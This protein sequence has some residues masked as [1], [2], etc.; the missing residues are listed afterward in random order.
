MLLCFVFTLFQLSHALLY[1]TLFS[2]TS[3]NFQSKDSKVLRNLTKMRYI[4]GVGDRTLTQC[5]DYCEQHSWCI[6]VED[7]MYVTD[8]LMLDMDNDLEYDHLTI[9]D[10]INVDGEQFVVLEEGLVGNI[11]VNNNFEIIEPLKIKNELNTS[12]IKTS[13]VHPE[14]QVPETEHTYFYGSN[15]PDSKGT[16]TFFMEH[17]VSND[18]FLFLDEFS[19][20]SQNFH[21]QPVNGIDDFTITTDAKIVGDKVFS[22]GVIETSTCRSPDTQEI[23]SPDAYVSNK[24]FKLFT[25]TIDKAYIECPLIQTET[26]QHCTYVTESNTLFS[27][28]DYVLNGN[29]HGFFKSLAIYDTNFQ[30]FGLLG[31]EHCHDVQFGSGTR[32]KATNTFKTGGDNVCKY[33]QFGFIKS[34][35]IPQGKNFPSLCKSGFGFDGRDDNK[36]CI[37][38]IE[39]TDDVLFEGL[40]SG[41]VPFGVIDDLQ[42]ASVFVEPYP[43]IDYDRVKEIVFNDTKYVY[44]DNS[45]CN[46]RESRDQLFVF[47]E[48]GISHP[49]LAP[50]AVSHNTAYSKV[51][52]YEKDQHHIWFKAGYLASNG[53]HL[54]KLPKNDLDDSKY[55]WLSINQRFDL[56]TGTIKNLVVQDNKLVLSLGT[57]QQPSIN[58]V[59]IPTE[60]ELIRWVHFNESDEK[61]ECNND[62]Y[63]IQTMKNHS[64]MSIACYKF[65]NRCSL[66]T[67]SI[68]SSRS[69]LNVDPNKDYVMTG[70]YRNTTSILCKEL[71]TESIPKPEI[72]SPFVGKISNHNV[73][74]DGGPNQSLKNPF[75]ETYYDRGRPLMGLL[76]DESTIQHFHYFNSPCENVNQG[77]I[78]I[79]GKDTFDCNDIRNG[80]ITHVTCSDSNCKNGVESLCVCSNKCSIN[81]PLKQSFIGHCPY[82]TVVVAI[83]CSEDDGNACNELVLTCAHVSPS[84]DE[85]HN[86]EFQQHSHEVDDVKLVAYIVEISLGILLS[87]VLCALPCIFCFKSDDNEN[88][89]LIETSSTTFKFD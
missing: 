26:D 25:T 45:E 35:D 52:I 86:C 5:S 83:E 48:N 49:T 54:R 63:I 17:W 85:K 81:E 39:G 88:E 69:C 62:E 64:T 79:T 34:F 31:A 70:I 10:I 6:A 76:L 75:I 15:G 50:G 68:V 56:G 28:I 22:N 73:I 13:L 60:N 12:I 57:S 14:P 19:S 42:V 55:F 18:M 46:L 43:Q 1:E 16:G 61:I 4:D 11:D 7:C 89:E 2:S 78:F 58:A 41:E 59:H 8:L 80:Y 38:R 67:G 27:M 84:T 30:Q 53:D 29:D 9:N 37:Q 82:D 24:F 71:S 44:C 32:T 77:S 74:R 23:I 20:S 40:S 47:E 3:F 21:F 36:L 51:A 33:Q 87:M 65:N 66:D 72:S